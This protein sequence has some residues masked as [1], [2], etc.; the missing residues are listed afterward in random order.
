MSAVKIRGTSLTA[1][2]CAAAIAQGW[3]VSLTRGS[4]IRLTP[5]DKTMPMVITSGTPGDIR[6]G[7]NFL[8][9]AKRS[10]LVWT[11]KKS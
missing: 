8:A 9:Q 4:H 10:G 7:R 2:V 3:E 11:K 6:A 1:Q 5:A